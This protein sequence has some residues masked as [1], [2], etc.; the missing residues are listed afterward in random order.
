MEEGGLHPAWNK[1]NTS[2]NSQITEKGAIT[3][4][5]MKYNT[6]IK[7]Q[8]TRICLHFVQLKNSWYASEIVTKKLLE[9]L[10]CCCGLYSI[11]NLAN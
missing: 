6:T 11:H 5:P 10:N 3:E 9:D 2:D 1:G 4:G 7:T 8:P